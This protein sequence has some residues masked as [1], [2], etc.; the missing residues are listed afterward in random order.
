MTSDYPGGEFEVFTVRDPNSTLVIEKTDT[1]TTK[2]P[3]EQV[4]RDQDITVKVNQPWTEVKFS[5][6]GGQLY[7]RPELLDLPRDRPRLVNTLSVSSGS[8][9]LATV[10]SRVTSAAARVSVRIIGSGDQNAR[11]D[12]DYFA[13]NIRLEA[14]S[15]DQPYEGGAPGGLREDPFVVRV[16]AGNSRAPGQVIKFSHTAVG[17]NSKLVPVPGTSVFVTTR[18]D[19][20][21]AGADNIITNIP[22]SSSVLE[23]VK[24]ERL[25]DYKFADL[26][27]M[28][29]QTDSN[30]E[31]K[32]YL[33][34]GT[35]GTGGE[36]LNTRG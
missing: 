35:V 10:R 28:F 36:L 9:G 31:A 12:I 33:L 20:T 18:G 14:V 11:Y 27:M 24:S 25:A 15:G 4:V 19:I 30:G 29:T 1:S 21:L 2:T 3:V 32:V 23:P 34:L 8:T 6:T 5:I 22:A 16:L 7:L 26:N 17:G 13:G